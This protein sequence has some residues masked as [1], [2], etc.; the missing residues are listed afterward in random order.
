[1]AGMISLS[2]KKRVVAIS[3]MAM[4]AF[5]IQAVARL[6]D[7]TLPQLVGESTVIAYG[8]TVNGAQHAPNT[9]MFEPI[10][11]LKGEAEVKGKAFIVCQTR[12]TAENFELSKVKDAYILFASKEGACYSPVHA[13][14]STILVVDDQAKVGAIID[15][16]EVQPVTEFLNKIQKLVAR[17]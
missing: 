6:I 11:I 13:M 10:A 16:P 15:Q 4:I 1:M 17:K 3:A 7:I 2:L 14:A 8:H 9:V 12:I 5:S